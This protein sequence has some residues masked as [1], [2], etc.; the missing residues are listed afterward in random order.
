MFKCW[1]VFG[2]MV[3]RGLA[4]G[5]AA[6]VK[7]PRNGRRKVS[8]YAL[9][10]IGIAAFALLAL[11]GI[12]GLALS[13]NKHV[14]YVGSPDGYQGFIPRGVISYGEGANPKGYL[15]L[16]NGTKIHNIIWDGQFE[17]EI[18]L[19]YHIINNL[20]GYFVRKTNPINKE[21]YVPLQDVYVIKGQVPIKQVTLEG[22]IY[23]VILADKIDKANIA[24]FYTY[25]GWINNFIAAINTPDT[26][27]AELPADDSPVFR[28]QN[29]T[30]T[31]AY[32]VMLYGR[33]W[34]RGGGLV[35]IQPNGNIIPYGAIVDIPPGFYLLNF[36]ISQQVYDPSS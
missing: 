22:Q 8:R 31:V 30:G 7:I 24:G 4:L 26:T 18:F 6:H 1:M 25:Q 32:Q 33:Y 13:N 34:F 21:R 29:L 15:I 5:G 11:F 17:V 2:L 14:N 12:Y 20:N 27:A 3:L 19:N 36:Y 16:D 10:H 35:L 28:W 23:Y 9:I